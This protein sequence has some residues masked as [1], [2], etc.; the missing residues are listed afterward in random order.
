MWNLQL[1]GQFNC[2]NR[3]NILFAYFVQLVSQQGGKKKKT[4][5]DRSDWAVLQKQ[6]NAHSKKHIFCIFKCLPMISKD[7]HCLM[8]PRYGSPFSFRKPICSKCMDHNGQYQWEKEIFCSFD[9]EI[10]HQKA[11]HKYLIIYIYIYAYTYIH[12]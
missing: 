9:K 8:Q 2:H 5:C 12:K 7:A 1:G 3:H 6:K 11:T 4:Y 10:A